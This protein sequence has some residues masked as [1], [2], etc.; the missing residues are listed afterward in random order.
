MLP[1]FFKDVSVFF[2][3]PDFVNVLLCAVDEMKVRFRCEAGVV[4]LLLAGSE[5][6]T[7]EGLVL[8]TN[9][10]TLFAWLCSSSSSCCPGD[11]ILPFVSAGYSAIVLLI[12][13]ISFKK[14]CSKRFTG[15]WGFGATEN[16]IV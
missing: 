15:F 3:F 1:F 5:E 6:A 12:L 7:C 10:C 8:Q 4:C 13:I 2:L 16:H 9:V 11:E 14:R